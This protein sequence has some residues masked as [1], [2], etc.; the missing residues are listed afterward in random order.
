MPPMAV[1]LIS[2]DLN[3]ERDE[4]DYEEFHEYIKDHNYVYLSESSYAIVTDMAPVEVH[5]TIRGYLDED[6]AVIIVTLSA[7]HYVSHNKQVRNWMD[8]NLP[9]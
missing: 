3:V 5:D 9:Q 1:L 2:Y 7:P 8:L 6:D 4:D